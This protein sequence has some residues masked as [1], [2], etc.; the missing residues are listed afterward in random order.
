LLNSGKENKMI[1]R[2]WAPQEHFLYE[3]HDVNYEP[4]DVTLRNNG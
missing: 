1:L 3:F 2:S 4:T